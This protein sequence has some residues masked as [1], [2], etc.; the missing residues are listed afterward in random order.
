MSATTAST[1]ALFTKTFPS[2]S[3]VWESPVTSV[4]FQATNAQNYQFVGAWE[5]IKATNAGST[6]YYLSW[7]SQVNAQTAPVAA[8]FIQQWVAPKWSVTSGNSLNYV[9]Q[10]GGTGLSPS[11]FIRDYNGN[12]GTDMLTGVYTKITTLGTTATDDSTV[13]SQ[14]T[15]TTVGLWNS[16]SCAGLRKA[17]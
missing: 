8:N 16:W 1:S 15:P 17:G 12:V 11:T 4:E 5:T 2:A 7:V 6:D 10:A 9:C 14:S 13:V 3:D